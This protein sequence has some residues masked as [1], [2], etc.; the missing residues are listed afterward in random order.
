MLKGNTPSCDDHSIPYPHALHMVD[1][2]GDGRADFVYVGDI[3]QVKAYY[4]V[5]DPNGNADKII[6]Y[7]QGTLATGIGC[8]REQI[9]FADI[10]G[11]GRADYLCVRPDSSVTGYR[12]AFFAGNP[13]NINW[14]PYGDDIATGIGRPGAGVRFADLSGDGRADYLYVHPNGAVDAY[15]NQPKAGDPTKPSWLPQTNPIA[16]GV[17][18]K[19][20][21]I[22]FADIDGDGRADYLSV[23]HVN[24]ATTWNRN[25]FSKDNGPN[26]A[27]PV[28][29][30]QKSLLTGVGTNGIGIQFADLNGDGRAGRIHSFP[31]VVSIEMLVRSHVANNSNRFH[32]RRSGYECC[33][34]IL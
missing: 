2:S 27:T 25:M 8:K 17:G 32:R 1:L 14:I 22:I 4:S 9:H 3:G 6:W 30:G 31:F 29:D 12:N 11:D 13:G 26:A 23:S 28:W 5:A 19:R 33:A 16:T 10:D 21:N 24:G 7:D 34:G 15:Q 18:S 20:E